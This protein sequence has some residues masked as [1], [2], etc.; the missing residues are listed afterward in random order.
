MVDSGTWPALWHSSRSVSWL[1]EGRAHCLPPHLCTLHPH[2]EPRIHLPAAPE[3]SLI[4]PPTESQAVN[5]PHS[6]SYLYGVGGFE[7]PATWC[8]SVLFVF[9]AVF[10]CYGHGLVWSSPETSLRAC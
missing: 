1:A 5:L 6:R 8:P 7:D 2:G 3:M 9:P 4:T 10:M